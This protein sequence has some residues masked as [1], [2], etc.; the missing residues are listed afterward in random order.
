MRPPIRELPLPAILD[1]TPTTHDLEPRLGQ[2]PARVAED[3]LEVYRHLPWPPVAAILLL[4][5]AARPSWT[6]GNRLARIVC[7]LPSWSSIRH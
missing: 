7:G 5:L 4:D 2:Q 3:P 6:S 1:R